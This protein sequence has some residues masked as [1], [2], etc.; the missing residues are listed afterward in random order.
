MPMLI[1]PAG[2][3]L[4][5]NGQV[6][7]SPNYGNIEKGQF[8]IV[9]KNSFEII[10]SDGPTFVYEGDNFKEYRASSPH[11]KQKGYLKNMN[12]EDAKVFIAKVKRESKKLIQ[13]NPELKETVNK[14]INNM[15]NSFKNYGAAYPKLFYKYI[16][17]SKSLPPEDR[18]I[19]H[20]AVS[21]EFSHKG[22]TIKAVYARN[23]NNDL[24]ESV[25]RMNFYT[26]S[27]DT[28]TKMFSWMEIKN[29]DEIKNLKE[30]FEKYVNGMTSKI[31]KHRTDK[32]TP[33]IIEESRE[34]Y[35]K[36]L[37]SLK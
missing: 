32:A 25:N 23:S 16:E 35:D 37:K 7:V 21:F 29:P 11:L 13:K 30:D 6:P 1:P 9:N 5:Q 36:K 4:T 22:K 34:Y 28:K 8:C 31:K 20:E 33:N 15:E 3:S 10:V 14:L 17:D 19:K 24:P 18:G 27:A 26:L 12:P 2:P